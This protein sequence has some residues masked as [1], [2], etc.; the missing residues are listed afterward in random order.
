MNLVPTNDKRFSNPNF[1]RPKLRQGLFSHFK[2]FFPLGLRAFPAGYLQYDSFCLNKERLIDY[3]GFFAETGGFSVVQFNP[4]ERMYYY[5]QLAAMTVGWKAGE[6]GP[7]SG[8]KSNQK[9]RCNPMYY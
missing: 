7:R 9:F 4:Q 6:G 2:S 5:A 3:K 8:V 1:S